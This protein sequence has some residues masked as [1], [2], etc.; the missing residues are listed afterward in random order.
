[1]RGLRQSGTEFLLPDSVIAIERRAK[2]PV[3][4]LLMP[5][6]HS[7]RVLKVE[8]PSHSK[9]S[10]YLSIWKQA[11]VL[12]RTLPDL[13]K[14]LQIQESSRKKR[15]QEGISPKHSRTGTYTPTRRSFVGCIAFAVSDCGDFLAQ[16]V[17]PFIVLIAK[18]ARDR[19]CCTNCVSPEYFIVARPQLC[20]TATATAST[21]STYLS[22]PAD[23]LYATYRSIVFLSILTRNSSQTFENMQYIIKLVAAREKGKYIR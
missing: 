12:C 5:K 17:S 15:A 3:S 20:R 8:I 14:T 11:L 19:T 2:N 22:A 16:N 23:Y 7:Q 13:H 1:M 21:T 9:A 6:S 18:M 4:W 10:R